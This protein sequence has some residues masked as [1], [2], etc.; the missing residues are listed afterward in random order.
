MSENI[1]RRLCYVR[2]K[3][4]KITMISD[5]L[6]IQQQVRDLTASR[7]HVRKYTQIFMLK[8]RRTDHDLFYYGKRPSYYHGKRPSLKSC[9]FGIM[10]RL[11]GKERIDLREWEERV[12]VRFCIMTSVRLLIER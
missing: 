3:V 7:E 5:L 2:V 11:K 1:Y 6:K 10:K 4:E 12:K 8:P 9:C